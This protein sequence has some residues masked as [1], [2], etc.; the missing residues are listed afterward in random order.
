MGQRQQTARSIKMPENDSSRLPNL[1]NL[2][3]SRQYRLH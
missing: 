3:K 2:P 1:A